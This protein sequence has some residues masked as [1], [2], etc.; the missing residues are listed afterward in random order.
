[1]NALVR[2][3]AD[4]LRGPRGD[5]VHRSVDRCVPVYR[6]TVLRNFDVAILEDGPKGKVIHYVTGIWTLGQVADWC[7]ARGMRK[8]FRGHYSFRE[9]IAR[10]E[11]IK[12]EWG[13]EDADAPVRSNT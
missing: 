4:W 12:D 10:E 5:L 11:I 3:L 2:H 8:T 13:Y 7:D 9:F 1:M 6:P